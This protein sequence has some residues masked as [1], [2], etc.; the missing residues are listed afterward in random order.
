MK[1]LYPY[2]IPFLLLSYLGNMQEMQNYIL[3]ITC[4]LLMRC[5]HKPQ[6]NLHF[7]NLCFLY[8]KVKQ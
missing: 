1:Y 8:Q 4:T 7:I 5:F 3:K 6:D 2:Y